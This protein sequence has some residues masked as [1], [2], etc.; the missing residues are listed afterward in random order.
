MT[1]GR[2]CRSGV[3]GTGGLAATV[4]L[5]ALLTA[6]GERP[7]ETAEKSGAAGPATG[8]VPADTPRS[9]APTGEDLWLVCQGCHTIEAGAPHLVG[10]NLH[11]TIGQRAGSREGYVYSDALARWGVTW[12]PDMLHGF[13]MNAESMVPGTWMVYHNVLT[14]QEVARLVDYIVEVSDTPPGEVSGQR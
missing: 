11:G 5:L 10:P 2:R 9:G 1:A 13:I 6:C 7:A 3:R 8:S 14:P 12:T 4:A